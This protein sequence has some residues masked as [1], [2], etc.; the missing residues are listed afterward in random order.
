VITVRQL[1]NMARKFGV[2]HVVGVSKAD[3]IRKIQTAEGN[4]PC[5]RTAERT[6]DRSDCLWRGDCVGKAAGAGAR[7]RDERTSQATLAEQF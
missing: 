7:P 1:Q 4:W 3:L 6:C 2:K 5:F